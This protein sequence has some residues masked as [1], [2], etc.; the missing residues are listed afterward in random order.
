MPLRRGNVFVYDEELSGVAP[1]S[2]GAL[3]AVI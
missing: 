3:A 2:C 1:G